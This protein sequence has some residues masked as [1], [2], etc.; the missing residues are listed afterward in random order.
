MNPSTLVLALNLDPNECLLSVKKSCRT[1]ISSHRPLLAEL[2]SL[3]LWSWKQ[4]RKKCWAAYA[5]VIHH[6][7]RP[8]K[9]I[10]NHI[11]VSNTAVKIQYWVQECSLLTFFPSSCPH[12]TVKRCMLLKVKCL[13][14]WHTPFK[15]LDWCT[16][17]SL[18]M[19]ISFLMFS[20]YFG[21]P[22][23]EIFCRDLSY[24]KAYQADKVQ[25]N[26]K[27]LMKQHAHRRADGTIREAHLSSSHHWA[28]TAP[29]PSSCQAGTG[30]GS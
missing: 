9:E 29:L 18:K 5:E 7:E 11:H 22:P 16:N 4:V 15:S 28:W 10:R 30:D 25:G 19:Q 6:L 21:A 3:H 8:D 14:E 1:C 26:S 2:S 27:Q 23:S 17:H 12:T 24:I 13:R 20:W